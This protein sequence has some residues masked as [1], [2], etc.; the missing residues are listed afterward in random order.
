MAEVSCISLEVRVRG[1]ASIREA[2]SAACSLAE[3]LGLDVSF[4]FSGE[5]FLVGPGTM[6]TSV[7]EDFLLRTKVAS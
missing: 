2:A 1:G 4:V 3:T 6:A 5:R 7:V